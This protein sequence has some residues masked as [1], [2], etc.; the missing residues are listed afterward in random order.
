MY[1]KCVLFLIIYLSFS[2]LLLAE[3]KQLVDRVA[4]VVNKDVITQSEV[5][6]LFR[7]IYEQIVKTNKGGG[8][9]IQNELESM[10]LK[11]LNQLIEDRLVAQEAERLGITVDDSEIQEQ[12]SDFKKQFP[13]ETAFKKELEKS[14]ISLS[15]LE[16]RFKERIAI[17]KLH[18]GIIR[19]SVV[20]SPSEAEAYY[21]EHAQ[22][23]IEKEQIE[24]WCITLR[25]GEEAITKGTTDEGVKR[26]A[27]EI[28]AQ[29]KAGKKFE[30]LAKE[31]S[32]DATATENGYLGFI[33]RGSLVAD[34]DQVVFSLPENSFSDVLETE[35]AY[36]I[37]KVGTKKPAKNRSFEEARDQINDLIFR[38]KAHER[39]LSWMEDLKKRSFIS[40]R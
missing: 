40:I 18:Q 15:E 16:K 1:K 19:G 36:H 34:I 29:L 33:P 14:G 3:E 8:L 27:G 37:F 4:A 17:T 32:E 25:K 35:Q 10:R 9:N 26:N 7:P 39:F 6:L 20:V 12:M 21:K 23:F 22:E 31:R 5:D 28:I 24:V 38:K 2:S 30:D 13:D 11:L